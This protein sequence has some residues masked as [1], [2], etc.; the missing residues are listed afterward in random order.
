MF[1]IKINMFKWVFLFCNVQVLDKVSLA[2]RFRW[3]GVITLFVWW[4]EDGRLCLLVKLQW[5]IVITS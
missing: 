5:T 3:Y 1:I 4:R 2:A